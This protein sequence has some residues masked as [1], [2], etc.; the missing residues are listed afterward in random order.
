MTIIENS[1]CISFEALENWE[2]PKTKGYQYS[3]I[4]DSDI[5]SILES[6]ELKGFVLADDS[7]LRLTD[8]HSTKSDNPIHLKIVGKMVEL[9]GNG[10][11]PPPVKII[12]EDDIDSGYCVIDGQHRLRALK[13]L[14][15]KKFQAILS[16][17]SVNLSTLL[18][19][20]R[21]CF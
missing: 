21:N 18:L 13:Y 16:G 19:S 20:Y 6:D 10:I 5:A 14:G 8:Q 15:K 2:Y 7:W 1:V 17:S 9:F 3:F 12:A 11:E 4:K